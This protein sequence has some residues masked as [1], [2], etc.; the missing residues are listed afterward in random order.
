[1]Q[2]LEAEWLDYKM[3]V[4]PRDAPAIQ[5]KETRRAFY[6]G[7]MAFY[8]Q[9]MSLLEPGPEPTAK[10]LQMVG[11]MVEELIEFNEK[12]KRGEA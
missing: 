8:S 5:I 6:A 11:D 1:M 2:R 4:V 9:V 12:V 3:R 7:A 10:D